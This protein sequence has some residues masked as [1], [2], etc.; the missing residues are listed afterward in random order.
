MP[1]CPKSKSYSSIKPRY[2]ELANPPLMSPKKI[3]EGKGKGEAGSGLVLPGL[4]K[5]KQKL[6]TLE[7]LM[8]RREPT[9]SN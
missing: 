9:R 6:Y 4:G 2:L 3:E 8:T 1:G 7:G 5:G